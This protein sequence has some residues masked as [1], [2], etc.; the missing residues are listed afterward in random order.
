MNQVH[1]VQST[2]ETSSKDLSKEPTKQPTAA[3]PTTT[4][5]RSYGSP[6]DLVAGCRI[7]AATGK[8]RI[9]ATK[10]LMQ[11]FIPGSLEPAFS[12]MGI[13]VIEEGREKEYDISQSKTMEQ[14][15]FGK[16]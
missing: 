2:S 9:F 11:Y 1:T 5:E 14:V 6:D 12:M 3:A 15:N 13:M 10:D 16:R 8:K 4:T 7:A